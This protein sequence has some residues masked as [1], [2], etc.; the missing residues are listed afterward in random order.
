MNIKDLIDKQVHRTIIVGVGFIL[1]I[2]ITIF[3]AFMVVLAD[4]YM[5]VRYVDSTYTCV[6]NYDSRLSE[7]DASVN[8]NY[9]CGTF[10]TAAHIG[11]ALYI[12]GAGISGYFWYTN[13]NKWAKVGAATVLTLGLLSTAFSAYYLMS[14]INVTCGS[15]G[16]MTLKCNTLQFRTYGDFL[17]FVDVLYYYNCY[18]AYTVIKC[19]LIGI[20]VF[21][22]L[23]SKYVSDPAKVTSK[24]SSNSST[25]PDY[26]SSLSW[27]KPNNTLSPRKSGSNLG[28]NSSWFN[29]GKA[30][31][32]TTRKSS[33]KLVDMKK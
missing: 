1:T 31:S 10:I 12:I 17:N 30:H 9:A 28:T 15:G 13:F 26:N 29:G 3:Y 20:A 11:F 7:A 5:Y 2:G 33:V 6:V 21:G 27:M 14:G 25:P 19:V 32:L 23:F 24:P 4:K 22:S 18:I 16:R 8:S